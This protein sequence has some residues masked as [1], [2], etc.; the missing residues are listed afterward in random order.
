MALHKPQ[1]SYFIYVLYF[2]FMRQ[3]RRNMFQF[4]YVTTMLWKNALNTLLETS[5]GYLNLH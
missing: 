4:T 2:I 1:N 3:F 5:H